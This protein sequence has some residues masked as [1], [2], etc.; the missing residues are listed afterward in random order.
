MTAPEVTT[1]M[2]RICGHR[3]ADGIEVFRGIRYAEAPQ[4]D[5]RW[6]PPRHVQPWQ[7]TFEALAFGP[8]CPQQA[9]LKPKNS[10][11][12]LPM[13]EDCLRLNIWRPTGCTS[14]TQ[15][16]VMVWLHGGGFVCGTS[17]L[18]RYDGSAFARSGV[19]LVSIDY[20]VGRLGFF[21]HPA[22]EDDPL[23]G[24]YG[25]M[26][27]IEA[28]RWIRDNIGAFGGN[29]DNITLFGESAG[30]MS[31]VSLLT[32]R[33]T[34]G[35]FHKAII[36]SGSGRHNLIPGNDWASAVERTFALAHQLGVSADCSLSS[37]GALR[38]V[39]VEQIVDGLDMSNLHE[40]PGFSAPMI[41]GVL[42]EDEPQ[43]LF[44]RGAFHR[45]PLLIGTTD[46]DLGLAP[47][48]GSV[49]EALAPFQ[50]DPVL[51]QRAYA[52]F[53]HQSPTHI[54]Q[55]LAADTLMTEPARFMAQMAHH[56]RTSAWLYRFAYVPQAL[57]DEVSGAPHG[58]DI[59]FVFDTLH[60]SHNPITVQDQQVAHLV[61][62]YWVNFAQNGCPNNDILPVWSRYNA[63][64]NNILNIDSRG[65]TYTGMVSP[66]PW[67]ARL[68]LISVLAG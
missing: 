20:R 10:R 45:V 37:L 54:A 14:H 44:Q 61:H 33:I 23:R 29:P 64:E 12:R 57:S 7:G 59:E 17:S 60:T 56:Y 50:H 16:P 28:L 22:L 4:G 15:R 41:D 68:D 51:H 25:L 39:P 47:P 46:A 1:P 62:R 35:L 6:Q 8:G 55:Q 65:V 67:T 52:E 18:A 9:W 40:R 48:V 63:L 26:D 3:T 42:I 49:E 21:A 32:S 43:T 30:G 31:I 24:N 34:H 38:A 27:Q 66:D 11:Q 2:G 58:S 36:Q 19:L 13:N 53:A 5:Y